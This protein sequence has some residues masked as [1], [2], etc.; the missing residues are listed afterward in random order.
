MDGPYVA[1]TITVDANGNQYPS[2]Y[3][4]NVVHTNMGDFVPISQANVTFV[5]TE[6]GAY[7]ASSG[8]QVRYTYA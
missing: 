8:Q 2:N 7:V 6:T 3:T 5:K 4:S 1:S